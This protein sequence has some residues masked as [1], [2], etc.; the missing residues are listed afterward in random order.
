MKKEKN[1]KAEEILNS[2][3]GIRKMEAPDF[4]FT[5]LK[6]RMQKGKEFTGNRRW[7]LR[8]V[9]AVVMLALLLAIN[10]AMLFQRDDDVNV[11][12]TD[13]DD[14]QTIASAYNLNDN[15]LYDINQ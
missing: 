12:N 15:S 10:A 2:L 5:R 4:F 9:Y 14:L 11:A 8:P 7:I 13:N 6:A 1:N 3:D